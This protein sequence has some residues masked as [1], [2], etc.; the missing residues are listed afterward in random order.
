MALTLSAFPVENITNDPVATV[1]TSLTEGA[2]YQ[3]L[4]IR[5]TIYIGGEEE[6]VAVL[7]QPDGI[8]T[9]DFFEVLKSFTGKCNVGAFGGTTFNQPTYGS[10]LITAWSNYLGLFETWT[11]SGRDI[12]SAI[13]S[14][15]S[16]AI[17]LSNDIGALSAGDVF[18]VG[19]EN[20]FADTGAD[21][22][23]IQLQGTPT[24]D[25]KSA[26]QYSGL[27]AGKL[28]GNKIY[29]M[30]VPSD[31]AAGYVSIV[32][33]VGANAAFSGTIF[34]RKITDFK[35]NPG[36]YYHIKFEEVYENGSNIT[37]I[38][39]EEWGDCTLFMPVVVREGEQFS[40][41]LLTTGGQKLPSRMADSHFKN[42]IEM[43]M[44]LLALATSAYLRAS[45]VIDSGTLIKND[46][47]NM[48]WG[49]F[50]LADNGSMPGL[51]D[52]D[53]TISSRIE[54][55][56][57]GAGVIV[58]GAYTTVPTERRCFPNLKAVSFVGDL[59]EE[60]FLFRGLHTERGL[61]EK[62]FYKNQ[63]RV[64]RVLRAFKRTRWKLRTLNETWGARKLL[65]EM[66]Y[67]EQDVW[68]YDPDSLITGYREA[69]VIDD[70]VILRDRNE[71][72]ESTIDIEYYE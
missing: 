2:S 41:F 42:G 71:L 50:T 61:A 70:D 23:I 64:R 54:A 68:L 65:H 46:L 19:L 38:G 59:G 44:R 27:L 57:L 24:G 47:P 55:I 48:G 49:M 31:S 16:G 43:E 56:T 34:T 40:D 63:D 4:R 35:N 58:S 37:T 5:A 69:V 10:E 72:I 14:D 32:H 7:E 51:D 18:V 45:T 62:S 13:D 26:V 39:A 1:Q 33:G 8:N 3:N 52:D 36:V 6:A 30:H 9:W 11:T 67:T 29:F 15:A 66:T 22:M 20:D 17:A 60:T 28:Q 53:E 25:G 21:D 12:T